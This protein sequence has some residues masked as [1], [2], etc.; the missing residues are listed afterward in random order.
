VLE[1][2]AVAPKRSSTPK[3]QL[4]ISKAMWIVVMSAHQLSSWISLDT[5][6][7]QIECTSTFVLNDI[8]RS[9]GLNRVCDACVCCSMRIGIIF[10]WCAFCV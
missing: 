4:Y 6:P 1:E 9:A 8:V 3:I 2:K 7:F 10:L 5:T